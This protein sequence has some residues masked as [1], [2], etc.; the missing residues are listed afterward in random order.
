MVEKEL[1]KT[2]RHIALA[3]INEDWSPHNTPLFYAIDFDREKIYFASRRTS[4][5]SKNVE[6]T[7]QGFAVVYDSNEFKG[8][9]Y[10]KLVDMGLVSEEN[11]EHAL[12][13]FNKKCEECDNDALAPDFHLIE[14]GYRLYEGSINQVEVYSNKEDENGHIKNE[15]RKQVAL[16]DLF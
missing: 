1:L 13:V 6:R 7:G 16:K 2:I 9:I 3:T 11:L 14:D 4:L 10:L 5:H 15:Q 12:G 8:G